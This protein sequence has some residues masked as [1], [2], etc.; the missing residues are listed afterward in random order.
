MFAPDPTEGVKRLAEFAPPSPTREKL[1]TFLRTMVFDQW[2]VTDELVDE[3]F[4]AASDPG[5]AA[6]AM[7]RWARRSPARDFEPACSGARRT[8]CASGCC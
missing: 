4:A 7:A 6:A 8:G 5:V 1:A 2:L 3:R